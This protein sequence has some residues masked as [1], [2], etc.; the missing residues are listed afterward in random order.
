PFPVPPTPGRARRGGAGSAAAAGRS[1]AERSGAGRGGQ[2]RGQHGGRHGGRRD[3]LRARAGAA[4][5]GRRRQNHHDPER[6]ADPGAGREPRAA[7]QQ[8]PGPGGHFGALQ[9]DIPEDGPPVLVEE[10]E[11]ARHPRPGGRHHPHPHHPPGHRHHPHLEPTPRPPPTRGDPPA[12]PVS[13]GE[14]RDDKNRV[15]LGEGLV[16]CQ[17]EAEEVTELMKQNF[18]RALERDGR[19]SDLDSRAQE[20]RAMGETFTRS[21][22]AVA[23]QQ[24]R[25]HRRWRLVVI[26]LAGLLLLLLL[27]IL[28]LALWL[29]RPPPAIITVTVPPGT[30]PGGD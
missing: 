24:R 1:G 26:G 9:D 12:T 27:L 8:K 28:G 23:R 6:G 14:Y 18:A 20:L 5:G 19:L 17:R 16:R 29:P 10:C 30:S 21:T 13:P 7:P 25:G 2:R 4:A 11:A 3:G 22:R 15:R